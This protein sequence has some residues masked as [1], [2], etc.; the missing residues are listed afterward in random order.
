MSNPT[1]IAPGLTPDDIR[2][3]APVLAKYTKER[4]TEAMWSR[5]GLKRRDRALTTVTALIVRGQVIGVPNY[6]K[7]ALDNGV[8]P[9]EISEL[10]VQVAFYAGWGHAFAAIPAI[11]NIFAERGVSSDQ[12]P[13]ADATASADT[14]PAQSAEAEF[15]LQAC[16]PVCAG[17]LEITDELLH[18]EVWQRPGLNP[19]D[20]SL[21]TVAA[22]I[23]SGQHALLPAYLRRAVA[24]GITKEQLS[25]QLTH[26]AFYSGWPLVLGAAGSVAGFFDGL[27]QSG[28]AED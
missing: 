9:A 4:I 18:G 23:A 26:L 19:R 20:R 8:T 6:V 16:M 2:A 15:E 12:L 11:K 14:A 13:S 7:K 10:V 22:L 5:P 27:P 21:I 28:G 3:V 1:P 25:E 17:V 24:H